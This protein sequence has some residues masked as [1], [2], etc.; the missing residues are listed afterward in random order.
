MAMALNVPL[1]KVSE[2][3]PAPRQPEPTGEIT[4]LR[5]P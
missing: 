2:D 3:T 5:R 1:I 4:A